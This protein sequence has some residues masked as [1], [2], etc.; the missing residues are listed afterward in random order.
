MIYNAYVILQFNNFFFTDYFTFRAAISVNTSDYIPSA[1]TIIYS[2]VGTDFVPRSSN[3]SADDWFP[4][5]INDGSTLTVDLD[6]SSGDGKL[7]K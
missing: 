1:E 4:Y 6:P 2:A 3:Y 7:F 5:V